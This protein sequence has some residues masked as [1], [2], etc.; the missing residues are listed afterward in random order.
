MVICQDYI[1][2]ILVVKDDVI[3]LLNGILDF[4]Y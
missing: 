3:F 4:N 2:N 1:Y